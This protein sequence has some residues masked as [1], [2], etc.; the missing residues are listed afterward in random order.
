MTRTICLTFTGTLCVGNLATSYTKHPRA[1]RL[2]KHTRLLPLPLLTEKVLLQTN[3]QGAWKF[4]CKLTY[5]NSSGTM[6]LSGR[7]PRLLF[8]EKLA[9]RATPKNVKR[10]HS[11][12][13][14]THRPRESP[15][16][17]LRACRGARSSL[18]TPPPRSVR[19]PR[20]FGAI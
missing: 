16:R 17:Y 11:E 12:E 8:K 19:L 9:P 20:K 5:K 18:A 15:L 14:A 7:F 6:G 13:A 1:P 3:V 2:C 4:Y 10:T